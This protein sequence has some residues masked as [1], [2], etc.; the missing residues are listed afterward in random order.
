MPYLRLTSDTLGLNETLDHPTSSVSSIESW[1]NGH[2]NDS[3]FYE[4]AVEPSAKKRRA[5]LISS[6]PLHSHEHEYENVKRQK[7]QQHPPVRR[8]AKRV[9]LAS[10]SGNRMGPPNPPQ[11]GGPAS[12]AKNR[13][14]NQSRPSTT[15]SPKKNRGRPAEDDPA[16][17]TPRGNSTTFT[18]Q[19]ARNRE[20]MT[21]SPAPIRRPQ[22]SQTLNILESTPVLPMPGPQRQQPAPQS[23]QKP[24]A[25]SNEHDTTSEKSGTSSPSRPKSPAK[26]SSAL[27]L[28]D[29]PVNY[30]Q[31]GSPGPTLP[32]A[33][34]ELIE[35]IEILGDGSAAVPPNLKQ[36]VSNYLMCHYGK[37]TRYVNRLF[38]ASS[39]SSVEPDLEEHYLWR[40]VIEISRNATRCRDDESSEPGWNSMVHSPLMELALGG[41]RE[42]AEVWFHN[43]TTARITDTSLLPGITANATKS[44]SK[45]VD[46]AMVVRPSKDLEK[47]IKQRIRDTGKISINHTDAAYLLYQP[48]GVS[49]ETKRA[50][51][52]EPTAKNQLATWVFAHFE[53]LEQ[54][55]HGDAPLPYLPLV[56]IQGHGWKFLIAHKPSPEE[57]LIY[58]DIDIGNTGTVLG[59]FQLLEA[60][61]RL[62]Q[63]MDREYKPW[64]VENVL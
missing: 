44:Q 6:S 39:F 57:V 45:M 13:S 4:R 46:F 52:D 18:S 60:L 9:G 16:E 42:T 26:D 15:P 31:F 56:M 58:R 35:D 21:A 7:R 33:A 20:H 62:A 38:P 51:I 48:I 54:L 29:I 50:G 19:S 47:R 28:A 37:S 36:S 53:K 40:R 22:T 32:E 64:F 55:R 43:V 24:A 61:R 10:I 23:Y 63:W 27:Q 14:R 25:G 12:T 2:P 34:I 17:D 11:T 3:A 49:I 1:V 59:I 5:Q 30:V 41:A 8:R